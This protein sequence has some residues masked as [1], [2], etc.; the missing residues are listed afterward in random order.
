ME[1]NKIYHGNNIEVLKTFPDDAIDSCVTDPPYGLKFMGKKWDYD[2][3]TVELWSEVFRVL[4]PGAHI[5]V[6]C[7][8]RTQ[9]RMT[10]NIE[11]AGFEIRDVITWHYGCLS[12][13]TEIL[14]EIGW[15]L[16]GDILN[17]KIAI[18]DKEQDAFRWEFPDKWNVYQIAD[19]CY[20]IKSDFTDQLVSRNHRCLI[21]RNG[22]L[23][24]QFAESLQKTE[25]VPYLEDM[26]TMQ[27]CI[28]YSEKPQNKEHLLFKRMQRSS[29]GQGVGLN[30]MEGFIGANT[31]KEKGIGIAGRKKSSMEGRY[32]LQEQEGVLQSCENKV[33]EMPNGFYQHEPEGRV[34]N[35]IQ[36]GN[37]STNKEGIDENGMCSPYRPQPN[38]QRYNESDVIQEQ[39]RTQK[40]RMGT[41]YNTTLATI[42]PIEYSGIVFCPTVS[43]G[44]FVARRNGKIFITG[45]SGF[46]KSLDISKAIDK[47]AGAEREV[48]GTRNNGASNK[49]NGNSFDD[50]NYEWKQEVKITEA[51]T[52]EAKEWE[53]W[54]TALKPATEFWTLARKP[55]SESTV[56]QNVLKHGT[57]GI[58][59]DG[60]R[61]EG[62]NEKDK[63]NF[64]QNREVIKE[65]KADETLY[66]LGMKTV[67][68]AEN[69]QGRFPANVIFDE[70]TGNELDK[71]SGITESSDAIRNNKTADN[72]FATSKDYTTSGHA[73]TGGASRFFY[74]PKPDNFERA[75]GLK[76]FELKNP[77]HDFGTKLGTPRDE[78]VH[79][80]KRNIHPTVKPIDLMRYL[81]RLVTPKGGIVLDPFNGSGTTGIAAKLE[82]M[83]YIGIEQDEDY[84]KLS[85]ARIAAWNPDK[86]KEQTLF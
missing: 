77:E 79:T 71:Q 26:P 3:P 52:D 21:E 78:R 70:F 73:D 29:K 18:Y 25:N 67:S 65:Y 68:S 15:K 19:T 59:I 55:I 54:G 62:I 85:E 33:C 14:T 36:V 23:I 53:G 50:D 64:H 66:E 12:D 46:P 1:V 51:K 8:T 34:C 58:N 30:R 9:H 7:G 44:A 63:N 76:N 20:R 60:C 32:H 69:P 39:C 11:D 13:D 47:K 49:P 40:V 16:I 24:F 31:G 6:A 28:S 82:L 17:K 48:I 42:T 38:E 22:E 5:L 81:V 35:G 41:S 37:G 2:I 43:T 10:V 61:I 57:G 83:K 75:K 84:C 72:I 80:Q 27:P 45:N 56:A 86:Y 4:K 74:C